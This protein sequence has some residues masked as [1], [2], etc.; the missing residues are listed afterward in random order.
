MPQH[1]THR[2]VDNVGKRGARESAA[3]IVDYWRGRGHAINAWS[4]KVGMDENTG[5][6]IY[7]VKSDLIDGLPQ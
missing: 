4:E 3:A 7:T 5:K 2:Q 6:P 1:S